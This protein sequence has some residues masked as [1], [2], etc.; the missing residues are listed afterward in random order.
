MPLLVCL[1]SQEKDRRPAVARD[2]MAH[3]D[4]LC[5]SLASSSAD[6]VASALSTVRA[7]TRLQPADMDAGGAALVGVTDERLSLAVAL[8]SAGAVPRI[9]DAWEL[10]EARSLPTLRVLPMQVLAQLL[11][12]L[13]AHQPN[14]AHGEA[15]LERLF[16]GP[17]MPRL[18]AAVALCLRPQGRRGDPSQD[19][20]LVLVALKLLTAM[21]SFARGKLAAGVWERY[22]WSADIH[23]RLLTM[24]R[25]AR[26]AP[27]ATAPDADV[28]TQYIL[29]L[30]ACVAQRF[31]TSLKVAVLDLGAEG[32][33]AIY[34]G[35][36]GDAPVLVQHV[37]LVLHEHVF[38]DAALA[39]AAQV[40]CL[41]E[42]AC[43]AL[44]RLYARESDEAP[45]AACVAD[46][47]HHFFLS[48][49]T[50]PGFGICYE[51][52]GWYGRDEGP[53]LCNKILLGV[54]R[55]LRVVDDLR[56]Q[57]LALRILGAC[58]ELVAP[59][60]DAAAR[61]LPL[62]PAADGTWLAC[63]A[64]FGR[65]LA[66]PIPPP[67][68]VLPPPLATVLNATAP[69]ALLRAL[70]RALRHTNALVQYFGCLVLARATQRIADVRSVAAAMAAAAEEADDGPWRMAL[71]TLELGWR[72][73]LPPIDAV[74]ALTEAP[75][76]RHEAALRV[77]ALYH[78]ALPSVAYDTRYDVGRLLTRAFLAPRAPHELRLECLA[79]VHA[80]AIAA[81]ASD[82]AFDWTARVAAPWPGCAPRS[83]LHFL[84]AAYV[85]VPSEV[86][87][88][89]CG[90]LLTRVLGAT[91]LFAHD[92]SE[93]EAWLASLGHAA[94]SLLNFLDDC[95]LRCLK[96]PYRY[97]ERARE[98]FGADGVVS[99]LLATVVEQARVRLEKHLFDTA[100]G[101]DANA[102]APV[103][104]YLTRVC[105]ALVERGRPVPPLR[106]MAQD[107]GGG[108]L[109]A[110]LDAVAAPPAAVE[111]AAALPPAD[112]LWT[113]DPR[114]HNAARALL[115]LPRALSATEARV[116]VVHATPDIYPAVVP[117][118]GDAWPLLLHVWLARVAPGAPDAL[119][120]ATW[121]A[122][123][124]WAA[125]HALAAPAVAAIVRHAAVAAHVARASVPFLPR[126]VTWLCAALEAPSP[127][128]SAALAPLAEGL[129]AAAPAHT[130]LLGAGAQ[131]AP[132]ASDDVHAQLARAAAPHAAA[133]DAARACLGAVAR[134]VR[135]TAPALDVLQAQLP[136]LLAAAPDV[137]AAV[138]SASLPPGLD[139][140]Q[141]AARGALASLRGARSHLAVAD[142]PRAPRSSNSLAAALAR[143][144]Y[145][146]PAA[147]APLAEPGAPGYLVAAALDVCAAQAQPIDHARLAQIVQRAAAALAT[148]DHA[149]AAVALAQCVAL[150]A[151]PDV[152]DAVDAVL[153]DAPH[154][155]TPVAAW[156]LSQAPWD[157]PRSAYTAA[158]LR[159]LVRRYA[160]DAS[161]TPATRASTRA[162]TVLVRRG[163]PV[164]A[165]LAEPVV[166]AALQHRATDVDAL[167][168]VHALLGA[169]TLRAPSRLANLLL[170]HTEAVAAAR[171]E[172]PPALRAAFVGVL[173]RLARCSDALATPAT[174]ARVLYLYRG[175][176]SAADRALWALLHAQAP[177]SD[178]LAAWNADAQLV[179]SAPRR[180]S[181]LAALLSLSPTSTHA[182]CVYMPRVA[183]RR[184]LTAEESAAADPWLVL[185]LMAGAMLERAEGGAHLTGLEWL[186]V[187]RTGA[188][189]VAVCALSAQRA[190]LRAFALALLGKVY[191]ELQQHTEFRERDLVLLVLERVRDAVPP[192][193]ATSIHGTHDT[194]PW[195]PSMATLFA[196][197]CLR[198]VSAPYM[199][200]F[201]VLF[202][203]LLQRPRLDVG[204]VPLL[205][206][207][208]HSTSDHLHAERTWLLRFLHDAL[209][210]HARVAATSSRRGI[211]RAKAEWKTFKRRHVWDLLLSLHGAV[212]DARSGH[213]DAEADR[214]HAAHIE[215]AMAA[216]ARVPYVAEELVNRRGLLQWVTVRI[217]AEGRL[218]AP[219]QAFWT[220]LLRDVCEPPALQHR[221]PETYRRLAQIDYRME[222]GL[223]STVAF[224]VALAV[225]ESPASAEAAAAASRLVYILC[226]YAA[227]R[228]PCAHAALEA[229]H[230]VAVLE[231][232]V[233][234]PAPPPVADELLRSVLL[235]SEHLTVQSRVQRLFPHALRLASH[236]VSYEP[237]RWALAADVADP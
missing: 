75:A 12:L 193:P 52:H 226:S 199:T 164:K 191:A 201:P 5:A 66:L 50:H 88:A 64:F 144:V 132:H 140:L 78:A 77:L 54:L 29:F 212:A 216:A 30:L 180:E 6:A 102:R 107:L 232:C 133:S 63:A 56:Q 7:E 53:A 68:G 97:A 237:R 22:H 32:L 14:H 46:V 147:A 203:F 82:A 167:R 89:S 187:L 188:L 38:Q 196:A 49:A 161:D 220:A 45:G 151:G 123:D 34:R 104:A 198:A 86:L 47:V 230:L 207:L 44:L 69:D 184:P 214:R 160:E 109:A 174:L 154:A 130:E 136:V 222:Q 125:A 202:R 27:P 98:M 162:L 28:R 71:R 176:L 3:A 148:A 92:V 11:V 221:A 33:P 111:H 172:E 153:R 139:V 65:V 158:V 42:A 138:L 229:Q 116:A 204:D 194:P 224:A 20:V 35:L 2:P 223:V 166:E 1:V 126:L 233:E 189:G 236:G 15:L 40:K 79:Q 117:R 173:V 121:D 165:H 210:A 106:A 205:Y 114:T 115:A 177:L 168:L 131:L 169:C 81:H 192:P 58:P 124:T 37:L 200:L 163:A 119:V 181:L 85:S 134:A 8:C 190:P 213:G 217:A 101:A 61:A 227:L 113:L 18:H 110:L 146:C 96:T 197:H 215:A 76:M 67:A 10:A 225:R 170:S 127:A 25:R 175:T 100:D 235:L 103:W 150:G 94:T 62:D 183:S 72:T 84:L 141:P 122:L 41:G 129:A 211:A 93:L 74:V 57:E 91:A 228:G 143:A 99:P 185:N 60:A 55:Q 206:N 195:L 90:E 87:R 135:P 39:R 24:R 108:A 145:V 137:A 51:D 105:L 156:L 159:A 112:D 83:H 80:L 171:A 152:A 128:M 182:A 179:P 43:H 118:A 31:H 178:A 59:Y 231:R 70:H 23:M 36:V 157:A 16:D 48:V 120:Q 208:L 149:W 95:A 26:D 73:R 21:T 142:M 155:A 13:S 209:A 218:G 4:A 19:N 219:R 9:L 186:A 234:F 17:W